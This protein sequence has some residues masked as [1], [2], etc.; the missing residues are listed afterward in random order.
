VIK[1]I[2]KCVVFVSILWN[3]PTAQAQKLNFK[4]YSINEG[5]SQNTVLCLLQDK[6]GFIWVGT[7][8]GLNKFDGYDFKYYQHENNLPTT[9]SH[10]QVNA[11]FENNDGKIWVG[12]YDGLNVFDPEKETFTRLNTSVK[13]SEPNEQ[14]TSITKDKKGNIWVGTFDGLLLYQPKNNTFSNFKVSKSNTVNSNRINYIYED[15]HANLWVSAGTNLY[16]F[17]PQTQEFYPLPIVLEKNNDL[18]TGYARVIKEDDKGR[19]WI[20][21]EKAGVFIYDES[22]NT[23]EN[24]RNKPNNKNS[25]P[26]DIV[27][28]IYFNNSKEIWLGTRDG[29]SIYNEEKGLFQNYSNDKYDSFSLSHNSVRSIL[30]D[31]AN[32]IWVGTFSGGVNLINPERNYFSLISE[33]TGNKPG[34]S[35]PI[36]S[37]ITAAKNDK[38]WIGTEGGGLNL[39]DPKKGSF[40]TYPLP[41]LNKN[42]AWNTVKTILEDDEQVYVGTLKGLSVFNIEKQFFVDD[43]IPTT[44]SVYSLA[45]NKDGLWI[46]TNGGG[47]ILKN[48]N[49]FTTFKHDANDPTSISGNNIFK[50]LKDKTDNLWVG[51]SWGLN[52]YKNKKFTPFLYNPKNPYSISN[53]NILSV[54][55]DSKNRI[56]VGTKGGGL[57]FYNQK[58]NRFYVINKT[59]GLASN[60]VQAI[61]EDAD[62]NLWISSNKGISKIQ[63]RFATLPFTSTSVIVSNYFVEDGLQSNQF[64]TGA[65]Y[66]DAK[67]NLYFGGLNGISYFNPQKITTNK[68]KPP[69]VFTDFLIKNNPISY[70]QEN[71]PLKKSINET[72]EITLSYDQAFITFKFAALNFTN[73]LKNQYA[74]KLDGFSGDNDWHYVGTQRTA[75]YTNLN[76]GT[77][78]FNVKAANDDGIWNV[79]VRKITIKVLPPWWKTWWSFIIY[80]FIL[81][82]LLYFYYYY[83]LKTAKLKN[84]LD[85]EQLSHEKDQELAQR[86]LTFFTNISHE[87]KTPLTLILAPVERLIDMNEG[88]NKIQNQLVLM[89][90]NGDRLVRLIDQ[91]LDF[92]K[93]ESGNMKLQAAEGNLVRFTKEVILAF[94]TYA[95]HLN[96]SLEFVTEKKS[97]KA[98]FDRDKFEKILYNLISNALKFSK[99]GGTITIKLSVLKAANALEKD[100]VKLD[101]ED[102]GFGISEKNLNLIFEPFKHFEN[103]NINKNGT[104]I[105]LSFT[106]S[107]VELHHGAITVKSNQDKTLGQTYTCFTIIFPVGFEHLDEEEIMQD[108]IDSENIISYHTKDNDIELTTALEKKKEILEKHTDDTPIMLIVEDNIDVLHFI[109]AHFEDSFK[110]FTAPNGKLGIEKAL[111]VIPDI[112]I[113][114]VMM[115]EMSGIELCKII[116]TDVNT[117]H[118]PIILL[119]ARTPLIYRIEGLETG[120]DDYVTKPFSI[121]MV[122]SRV[123]N[124]LHT[125]LQLREKYSRE[126]TL[127]PTNQAIT[128]LDEIFLN[129]VMNFIE[130][131]LTE[132]TLN[133]E[134]LGKE[135]FMSRVTLYRKIKSLTNL[136]VIEFIRS[137]RL[138]KAAQFLKNSGYNVGEVAYLV[139]FSDI[140][141]F[142]KCFKEQFGKTPKEYACDKT[143]IKI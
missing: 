140:D 76:A 35:F 18:K 71:S 56:W 63:F 119:T 28:E 118:I 83:S 123:W 74:F 54:F 3:I 68:F 6:N 1:F 43:V 2:V 120:A 131:N 126:I 87:I 55:V 137:I 129:K 84:D 4:H 15:K 124:L 115:P 89:K 19:V 85:F 98:W 109:T 57:N 127:Q 62:G 113:S 65:D 51:T 34:L 60:V 104:G 26:I 117:S 100:T 136:T 20:G 48:K 141:Y 69:V 66:K 47:L 16:R 75:T 53:N 11:L 106:K 42:V 24:L 116:K 58:N 67:G 142:R 33:E 121:K 138:K 12:T 93:F 96:I 29:L 134:D 32:N 22:K 8:D 59:T 27:R 135:V 125:R 36:V 37:T 7:E 80:A 110:V 49:G 72:E 91:L 38:L 94:E 101:V 10:N 130:N 14:I 41:S 30:K 61:N 133:V 99:E 31:K 17:N 39:I 143:I 23:V 50:I 92:R 86:K 139:G 88:N 5:L 45:K 40:I 105:G 111:E 46:G 102:N 25:L 132:S 9:I 70:Q 128:S 52:Y 79:N 77:Y 78:V 82:T 108:Y 107:L 90:R 103:Q 97:I 114:D 13:K 21:T 44:K 64:L 73:P 122:E 95:K 81:I 112:I